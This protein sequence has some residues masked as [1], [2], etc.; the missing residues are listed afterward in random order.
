MVQNKNTN[1]SEQA[2]CCGPLYQRGKDIKKLTNGFKKPFKIGLYSI[3]KLC[4]PQSPMV[5]LRCLFTVTMN[6][7]WLQHFYYSCLSENLIITCWVHQNRVDLRSKGIHTIISSLVIQH[8]LML[9][10]SNS[11]IFFMAQ[12]H[13]WLWVLH[14][15]QNYALAVIIMV[16]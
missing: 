1:Q 4:N 14:I 10:H 12:S 13:V 16:G 7:S 8:Y 6:H 11:G 5:V 15:F 3:L 2:E 9:C